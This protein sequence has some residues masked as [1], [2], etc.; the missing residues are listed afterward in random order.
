MT[1][2]S[3]SQR[4]TAAELSPKTPLTSLSMALMSRPWPDESYCLFLLRYHDAF[5][6]S[7]ARSASVSLVKTL[8]IVQFDPSRCTIHLLQM[9]SPNV[10]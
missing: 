3:F 10:A 1:H 8:A 6:S 4:P 5:P 2:I 7:Y 9:I